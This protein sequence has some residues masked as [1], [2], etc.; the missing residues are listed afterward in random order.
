MK[1]SFT[2]PAHV[3]PARPCSNAL[4]II[5]RYGGTRELVCFAIDAMAIAPWAF[6]FQDWDCKAFWEMVINSCRYNR[7]PPKE[8]RLWK[9]KLK[10]LLRDTKKLINWFFFSKSGKKASD[11][12]SK[13]VILNG[14]ITPL[15]ERER[16][17]VVSWC[18]FTTAGLHELGYVH[19]RASC[20]WSS[21]INTCQGEKQLGSTTLK[22]YSKATYDH[23]S[24]STK[25][26]KAL[27][28][29]GRVSIL[30][31]G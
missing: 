8:P 9:A 28:C 26:N 19:R 7:M 27:L 20:K 4:R 30:Q 29:W 22:G 1:G 13:A 3:L 10:Q 23:Y 25:I 16:N 31:Q 24:L 15:S 11:H 5:P 12:P 2:F 14:S 21:S 6:I 17:W 18:I